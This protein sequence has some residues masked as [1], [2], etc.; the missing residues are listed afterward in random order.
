MV[1]LKTTTFYLYYLSSLGASVNYTY[2]HSENEVEEIG[3]TGRFF[4]PLPQPYTPKHSANV[5]LFWERD[6]IQL[7][8][9]NRYNDTQLVN[10][11]GADGATWQDATNRLDFSSSYQVTKNIAITF[12]GL[13][14]TDDTRRVFF[15]T[16]GATD[17]TD[18]NNQTVVLEEGNVLEDSSI[19][20]SRTAAEFK[21]G[22]QFRVGI[23]GTF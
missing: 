9:A 18:G 7:R 19:T 16:N 14:L 6:G 13:N 11:G 22:R 20:T 10:D 1:T 4:K 12:Q 8:L 3:T 17:A 2:Q 5:T 15:T 23:R 21:T